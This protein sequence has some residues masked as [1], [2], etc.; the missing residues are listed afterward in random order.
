MRVFGFLGWYVKEEGMDTGTRY[1]L[2]ELSQHTP[3]LHNLS[4][5][6]YLVFA[7]LVFAA[8]IVW[9]WR[10]CCKSISPRPASAQTRLFGL[11]PD[12]DFLVPAFAFALAL[13]L[14][15]SPHYPWYVAWL[16]PFLALVPSLTAFA[17]VCGLFYMC[18]TALAVGTGAPQFLLNKILY[19]GV[20]IAFV[21]D[22]L[23]RRWPL[24]RPYFKHIREG[25]P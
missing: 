5:T 20:L 3:G 13:M 14:L 17:Y 23:I 16:V 12:A 22:F 19:G 21:L 11:P 2:L 9:S 1:F 25:Q 6:P 15:F 18:T 4:T 7:A 8:L 24:H 10:T